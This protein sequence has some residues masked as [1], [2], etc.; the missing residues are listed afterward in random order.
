MTIDF[1]WLID[2]FNIVKDVFLDV[3]MTIGPSLNY[4]FQAK[5]FHNTKS[6]KGFS[7]YICLV[8]LISNTL[9]VFFWFSKK[10]KYTLLV[11]SILLILMQLY[12][13][14]LCIKYKDDDTLNSSSSSEL[15]PINKT[16]R[17]K[18][19]NFIKYNLFDWSKTLN[20]K[21][22]WKWNKTI[23]YYKFFCLIILL[24]CI[25]SFVL[26]FQNEYYI[27]II[28]SLS[29]VLEMLCSLPQIIEM[30]KSK[31]QR[32]ISKIMV[33]MWFSGN[34]LKIYYNTVNNSPIQLIIGCYIQVFCN[35]ILL[36]QIFYYYRFNKRESLNIINTAQ[37]LH[38]VE[39]N[40]NKEKDEVQLINDEKDINQI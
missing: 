39:K 13:I 23:E 2:L 37:E 14:H 36:Y 9:K 27:S 8:N 18:V 32:N 3:F 1:Q 16:K 12:L 34:I 7:I 31:N 24:L 21:L 33:F 40:D 30:R 20:P 10:F 17:E 35:V 38:I 19:R 15:L 4:L 5:K 11:Q 29:I 26:G 28:G 25:F 22:I 6:S